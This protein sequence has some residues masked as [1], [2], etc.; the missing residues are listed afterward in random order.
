MISLR[1]HIITIAAV[2]LSLGLGIILGGSIGQNWINEKQ[3]TL[4][5]GLE[6]KYDQALQSNA[7]LQNQIQ[8][9]S[10]RIEQANEEFSAFVSKGFMPDLQEKTIGLWMNQGLKDEFIRPFLESVGMKVILIDES[11]PSPLPAY[12]I[13][14]VGAQ[15]P[16]WAHEWA[17][18]LTLQVEKANLTPAEQGKLLERIQ[19]VY[20][21]QNHEY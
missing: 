8:E 21:E 12:P 19:Q 13:L 20:Q 17:E 2:F 15:R 16:N 10:G 14:F 18:E 9:L 6:E 7:K 3:Q 1:Y 11:L 4:L 5:V